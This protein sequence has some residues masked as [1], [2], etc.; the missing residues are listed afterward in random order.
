METES[1]DA[2]LAYRYTYGLQKTSV[3][4]TGAQN[5]A[6]SVMQYYYDDDLGEFVLTSEDPGQSVSVNNIIGDLSRASLYGVKPYNEMRELLQNTGLHAHH[7]IEQ[8][9]NLNISDSVAVTRS[10]CKK[11]LTELLGISADWLSADDVITR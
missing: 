2:S 5:G 10:L 8:R 1:G 11:F 9:F 6:G 3:A 7:I 4:I